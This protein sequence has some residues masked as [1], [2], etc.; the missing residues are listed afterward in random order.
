M[1][2]GKVIRSLHLINLFEAKL[3]YYH[4]SGNES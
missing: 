1:E 3:E 4:A 2:S